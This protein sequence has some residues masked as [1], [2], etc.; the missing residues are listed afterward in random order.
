MLI[1]QLSLVPLFDTILWQY[2]V[3]RLLRSTRTVFGHGGVPN[4]GGVRAPPAEHYISKAVR[5]KKKLEEISR[6]F[7]GLDPAKTLSR[8]RRAGCLFGFGVCIDCQ[9]D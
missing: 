6:I 2:T 5:S 7:G 3:S 4:S 9:P 1:G 8:V